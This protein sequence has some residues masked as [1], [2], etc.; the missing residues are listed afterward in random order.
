MKR[1]A[2][3]SLLVFLLVASYVLV[4]FLTQL[5]MGVAKW[6]DAPLI[7]GLTV[8][9]STLLGAIFYF[10]FTKLAGIFGSPEKSASPYVLNRQFVIV[11]LVLLTLSSTY[12]A[13]RSYLEGSE[14]KAAAE[15]QREAMESRRLA[16]AKAAEA[17]RQRVAALTPEQRA[18]EEKQK[19]ERVAAATKA[20]ADEAARKEAEKAKASAD[21]KKRD[22]QLQIAAAG[23]VILKRAMKDPEAFDLRSLLVMSNGTACYEYRAKNSFGAILPSSAV[24]TSA[25]K[26]LLQERDGNAFVRVW[27]KNCTVSGGD[28][29]APLVKRTG[30]L[31]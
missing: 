22:T 11:A 8:F 21:K 2:V 20:A 30:I 7:L 28:E 1:N 24:L 16:V 3:Y 5:L 23:A 12:G 15:K 26:M 31:D 9:S 17:E 13:V 6:E 25:G 27:N 4:G 29:L 14:Q 10:V 19:R 18:A